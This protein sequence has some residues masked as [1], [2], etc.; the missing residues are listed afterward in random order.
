[1]V[2]RIGFLYACLLAASPVAAGPLVTWEATGA[3][4]AITGVI[5]MDQPHPSVGTPVNLTLSFTP[6][7]AVPSMGSLPG[8]GCMTVNLSASLTIGGYTWAGGGLGFTHAQL[9]ASI[10][11]N[12]TPFKETQFSLHSMARPTDSPWNVSGTR[13]FVFSYVDLLVQDAFPDT[14]T[15]SFGPFLWT[16]TEGQWGLVAPMTFQAVEQPT[17]VPEPGTLTLLGLGLA[18]VARARAARRRT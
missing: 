10:C 4:S 7:S 18:A 1:M 16:V 14:P 17:A 9:P 8:S 15:P 6:S 5:G 2:K 12:P 3:I 13:I 11:N